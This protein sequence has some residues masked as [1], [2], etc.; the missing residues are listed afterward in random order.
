[1]SGCP[2]CADDDSSCRADEQACN[3]PGVCCWCGRRLRS[4]LTGLAAALFWMCKAMGPPFAI[5]IE[6]H[7]G[8]TGQRTHACLANDDAAAWWAW[9]DAAQ[10]WPDVESAAA[11]ALR[12]GKE[13]R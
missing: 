1:M 5:H 8:R 7:A 2:G 10:E 3:R 12:P 4:D 13:P 9:H 11:G 6:V